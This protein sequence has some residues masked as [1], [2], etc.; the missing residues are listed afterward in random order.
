MTNPEDL[1][2]YNCP[3]NCDYWAVWHPVMV[4]GRQVSEIV[5]AEGC[6]LLVPDPQSGSD[7]MVIDA[8]IYDKDFG[9]VDD[10]VEYQPEQ[11]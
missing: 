1:R 7:V 2:L 8:P 5:H 4:K 9:W 10:V 6:P 3:H 11:G